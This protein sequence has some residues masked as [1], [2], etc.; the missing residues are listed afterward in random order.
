MF[1]LVLAVTFVAAKSV[2]KLQHEN[3]D[4]L[5]EDLV[6]QEEIVDV[7]EPPDIFIIDDSEY[8]GYECNIDESQNVLPESKP[9]ETKIK[10]NLS[11]A[12]LF[13]NLKNSPSERMIKL[14][15]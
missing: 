1:L 12:T 15:S 9:I 13:N 11:F 7:Q 6:D 10:K 8:S 3:F 14:S 5:E 4:D 2:S